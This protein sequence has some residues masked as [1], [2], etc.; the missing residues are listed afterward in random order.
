MITLKQEITL[1]EFEAWSGGA[2]TLAVFSDAEKDAIGWC[3]AE[4]YENGLTPTELNDI[5]WFER[6][7]IAEWLGYSDFDEL[8]EDKNA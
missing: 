6:D 5:L 8:L 4:E 7:L 2:D 1:S 3:I